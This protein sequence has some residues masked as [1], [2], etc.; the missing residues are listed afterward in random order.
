MYCRYFLWNCSLIRCLLPVNAN[1]MLFNYQSEIN[2]LLYMQGFNL[3]ARI[4]HATNMSCIHM[5]KQTCTQLS[6]CTHTLRIGGEER[7]ALHLAQN[8]C[9][10]DPLMSCDD[11]CASAV[12]RISEALTSQ[13]SKWG[14]IGSERYTRHLK[15]VSLILIESIFSTGGPSRTDT[16]LVYIF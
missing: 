10:I 13:H 11:P 14:K 1:Y 7:R 8:Q 16:L 6:M 3:H 2:N 5:D 12:T 4:C 9:R 15:D